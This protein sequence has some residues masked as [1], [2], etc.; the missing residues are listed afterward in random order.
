[1]RDDDGTEKIEA[2]SSPAKMHSVLPAV[3][4]DE[5]KDEYREESS[6]FRALAVDVFQ[7]CK[8]GTSSSQDETSCV[9]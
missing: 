4:T 2:A 3:A 5:E 8:F 7:I 6:E 9:P 1:M